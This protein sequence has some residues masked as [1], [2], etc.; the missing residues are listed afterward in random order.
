M[1]KFER[2]HLELMGRLPVRTVYSKRR[3][4]SEWIVYSDGCG[5][6][7]DAEEK[8]RMARRVKALREAGVERCHIAEA[9]NVSSNTVDR[10]IAMTKGRPG[11]GAR[12]E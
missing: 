12:H 5:G 10:Y 6:R 4:P 9:L 8:E 2:V 1:T 3:P 11:R 7:I